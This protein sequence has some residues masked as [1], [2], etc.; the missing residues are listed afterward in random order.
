ML[1][2]I[3][4]GPLELSSYG[5]MIL[6]GILLGVLLLRQRT[7][8][9]NYSTQDALFALLYSIIG[10]AIGA[11]LFYLVGVAPQIVEHWEAITQSSETMFQVFTGLLTSGFVFYG[12]LFGGLAG[13]WIYSR[14]FH[15]SFRGLL[16]I[17]IPVLPFIHAFGRIGC[18]LA[19]CCYGIEYDGFLCVTFT[20]SDI[21][22]SGIPLFP[23]Q[24]LESA[25]LFLLTAFLLLY[26]ARARHPRTLVGWYLLLYGLIRMITEL[27]R[28]DLERG[29]FLFLSTS[30]WI[31]VALIIVA[32]I[33]LVRWKTPLPEKQLQSAQSQSAQLSGEQPQSTQPS[34]EQSQSAQPPTQ[35]E[36]QSTQQQDDGKDA[37]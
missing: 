22:P 36:A 31:S 35:A 25:L 2:H 11:K 5:T 33:L 7:R 16:E 18:F 37:T 30:Q 1:P 20:L 28:G 8:R 32:I 4:I 15:L 10:L 19:G 27:F 12:G 9:K 24:L 34:A 29:F 13:A 14:Q 26:D 17:L 6:I 21:A 3:Q 23:V